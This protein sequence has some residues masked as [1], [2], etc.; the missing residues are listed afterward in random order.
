MH[1]GAEAKQTLHLQEWQ[2]ILRENNGGITGTYFLR[3][4]NI[5]VFPGLRE[6]PEHETFSAKTRKARMFTLQMATRREILTFG[7]KQ[8]S[9]L[10]GKRNI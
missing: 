5:C 1:K 6:V 10:H 3:S 9:K 4:R 8:Q 7:E 2:A